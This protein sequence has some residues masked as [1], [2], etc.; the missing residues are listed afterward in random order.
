MKVNEEELSIIANRVGLGSHGMGETA[1]RLRAAYELD[2]LIVTLGAQGALAFDSLNDSIRVE[3]EQDTEIVDTVGAGD[4][5]SSV[6]L[7]GLLKGWS[8][9]VIMREAQ[10]F[11]GRICAQRGATSENHELYQTIRARD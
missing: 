8:V 3:P 5:F 6:V 1:R 4:A 10:A 11:A 9:T 2:M 7:F